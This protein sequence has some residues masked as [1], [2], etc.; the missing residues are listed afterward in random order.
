MLQPERGDNC[1]ELYWHLLVQKTRNARTHVCVL[2]F[3]VHYA[4]AGGQDTKETAIILRRINTRDT[5]AHTH[6]SSSDC[7][8][9]KATHGPT[10]SISLPITRV[11]VGIFHGAAAHFMGFALLG[12]KT[13]RLYARLPHRPNPIVKHYRKKIQCYHQPCHSKPNLT[14]RTEIPTWHFYHAIICSMINALRPRN[15]FGVT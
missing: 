13:Q 5:H 12:R 9:T 8:R 10:K 3:R 15:I 1:W 11:W 2:G 6:I 14:R 7:D 4:G